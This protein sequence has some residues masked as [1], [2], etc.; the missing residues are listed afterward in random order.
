LPLCVM[1]WRGL[2]VLSFLGGD[3]SAL[4]DLL[5]DPNDGVVP[6]HA[7]GDERARP[8]PPT[9][10]GAPARA[11]VEPAAATPHDFADLF[12]MPV[13]SRLARELGPAR[14]LLLERAE[15]PV[16]D[17]DGDLGARYRG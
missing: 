5:V 10:A 14:L 9:G 7:T 4:A 11:L 15:A 2:D 16:L 1:R 13:G 17:V 3:Q 12:G 6:R 8:P